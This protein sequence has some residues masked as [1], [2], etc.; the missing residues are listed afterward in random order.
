LLLLLTAC[1]SRSGFLLLLLQLQ[2]QEG[3]RLT[4]GDVAQVEHSQHL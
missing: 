2:L 4:R 1:R 3:V